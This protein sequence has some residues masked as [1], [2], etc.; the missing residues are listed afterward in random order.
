MEA[1]TIIHKDKTNARIG[2]FKTKKHSI[3]TPFFM[4]VATKAAAKHLD[5]RQLEELGAKAVISN[6]MILHFR[7]G[8]KIIKKLGGIGKFMNFSG[9]NVTDSGGFQMYSDSIYIKSSE[10]G[11]FF[12]NPFSG[13][14][15]LMTPEKNMEIQLNIGSEVAMCLDSMP[16]YSHSKEEIK[17]AVE[18]TTMWARRCKQEHD[19]LQ[20]N[21]EKEKRQLLFGITQGGIYEDLRKESISELKELNFD[22]YSIGGLG[23]GETFEEEMKIVKLQKSVLPENKPVYLM[24]IGNPAEILEAISLGV[25]MFDSRMP[26]QSARRGTLFTSKGKLK[27]LN[28]KYESDKKPID[29]ECNCFVCKNYSRAYIKFLLSQEEPVGKELASYHNLYYLNSLIEQ[30]KKHIK[31]RSFKDFKEKIKKAYE[32]E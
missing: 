11:V 2:V 6:S 18:K 16:L 26:T 19:K 12:R 30:A 23:L 8:D 32:K 4:P 31:K 14:K 28:K 13:E 7:P 15:I 24:G 21:T 29:K 27:I 9:I 22:G 3:E 10:K 5:S 17:T 25:D 20:K 1:F